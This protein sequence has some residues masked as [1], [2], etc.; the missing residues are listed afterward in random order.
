MKRITG[1]IATITIMNFL[2]CFGFYVS[3]PI[4]A[5]HFNIDFGLDY[6]QVGLLLGAPPIISAFL[7]FLGA[8]ISEKLGVIY[9]LVTGLFLLSIAYIGYAYINNFYILFFLCLIQGFSRVF[10]EP[11]IKYLF[12]FHA[13]E[14][15]AQD[16]VFRIKYFT[17]CLG[18]IIG[19]LCGAF[20]AVYGKTL[21]ILISVV[22]FVLLAA[23]LVA[24]RNALDIRPDERAARQKIDK[25]AVLKE[26]IR[27]V[28]YVLANTCVFFVFVQFETM[29]SLSLKQ[30]SAE[31]EKLFSYLLVLNAVA[32]IIL[33]FAFL[34]VSHKMKTSS[35]IILGNIAFA[36]AFIMYAFSG[37]QIML[38]AVATIIFTVGEVIVIPA[39][40]III[41][42]IAPDD[43]KTLYFGFAEFR[44]LGFSLG[45]VFSGFVLEYFGSAVMFLSSTVVLL[46]ASILYYLPR[47]SVVKAISPGERSADNI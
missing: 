29:F 34:L 14:S 43:K 35:Y 19:P 28:L 36:I 32:G 22:I 5:L 8:G 18:A 13:K 44:L 42:E 20:L 9:S 11:V 31:P 47:L 27:L 4:L 6:F 26:D 41:D 37:G 7:G 15:S 10:W 24:G 46:L 12:T 39:G 23:I 45:P 3:L 2:Y 1:K 30:F 25:L 17:I 40:D 16:L 38:L 33:Q 21:A